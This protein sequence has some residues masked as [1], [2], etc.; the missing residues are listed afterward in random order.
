[1]I[2][3]QQQINRLKYFLLNEPT[4]EELVRC[5][6]CWGWKSS[7]EKCENGEIC[8]RYTPNDSDLIGTKNI[9]NDLFDT[10][11]YLLEMKMGK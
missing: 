7:M 11:E 2:L 9:I 1:M 6:E 8:E 10:I 3:N 5:N 4:E